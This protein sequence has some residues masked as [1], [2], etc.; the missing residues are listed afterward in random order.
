MNIPSVINPIVEMSILSCSPHPHDTPRVTPFP[1]PVPN[2]RAVAPFSI[3]EYLPAKEYKL[4]AIIDTNNNE[5]WDTGNYL[6]KI[7]PEK[8]INYDQLINVRS[9]WEIEQQWSLPN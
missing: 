6:K 8:V 3:F 7:Q 9:N 4:R 2:E 5:A 1:Y